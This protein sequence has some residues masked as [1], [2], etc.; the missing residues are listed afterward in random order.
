MMRILMTI[1]A[2]TY[3]L[4]LGDCWLEVYRTIFC[5]WT[6]GGVLDKQI[7]PP[8]CKLPSRSRSASPNCSAEGTL[9]MEATSWAASPSLE[10]WPSLPEMLGSLSIRQVACS[11][12]CHWLSDSL[13]LN[14]DREARSTACSSLHFVKIRVFTYCK[15]LVVLFTDCSKQDGYC[16]AKLHPNHHHRTK[17]QAKLGVIDEALINFLGNSSNESK[18]YQP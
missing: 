16:L 14:F 17:A 5:S 11:A 18:A 1:L 12:T 6:D 13:Q 7:P 15:R 9:L 3:S 8:I 4:L 2:G 10:T